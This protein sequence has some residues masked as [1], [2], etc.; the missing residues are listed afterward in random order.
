[1]KE[2]IVDIRDLTVTYDVK[3]VLWDIDVSFEKAKLTAIIGPNGAGKSTLIKSILNIVK[4]VSGDISI[5]LDSNLTLKE[6]YKKIAYVPQSGSVDWDFPATVYDVVLMGRY[7]HIGWFKRPSD[8]DKK[9]AHQM[10]EK[11]GMKDYTKR[12][13]AQL[14]GGQQQRVFLA[15]ALAQEAEIYILDE[16]LK[17]I[18]AQTESILIDLLKGLK[19][20]GKSIIIIHHNLDTIEEYFDNIVIM[21]KHIIA[22]GPINEVF[23]KENL[24][25]AYRKVGV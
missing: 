3:P 9:I 7:G 1:M 25:R 22:D 14:S 8:L 13:I 5:N 4:P 18:D 24:D 19:N 6:K 17:G 21:N 10:I 12:Q 2:S 20:S 15:R 11:V 23:T 16:P